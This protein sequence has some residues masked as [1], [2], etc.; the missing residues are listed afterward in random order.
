MAVTLAYVFD[1]SDA[2]KGFDDLAEA[3]LDLT[4]L[5]DQIGAL[6]EQSTRDRIEDT[7]VAPDGVPWPASLRAQEDGGKT[8]Y[9]SGQLA[10]SQTHVA[11]QDTAEI[12]SNLIY[13]GVHQEGKTIV[14]KNADKLSFV[15]A[16]G[17]TVFVDEVTI[18]PRPYLGVS[19]EDEED[20]QVL[21]QDYFQGALG[22]GP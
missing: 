10:A 21:V 11:T 16:N 12:G 13:A 17:V 2:I 15:L 18:P 1:A 4:P 3:A 8:L 22:A 7:N 9:D 14:P 19:A 5:M 20:I 6:L